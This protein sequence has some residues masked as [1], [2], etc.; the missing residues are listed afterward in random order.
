M[1]PERLHDS[2]FIS[3]IATQ[4]PPWWWLDSASLKPVSIFPHHL[5][6]TSQWPYILPNP[7]SSIHITG[8]SIV[9][10]PLADVTFDSC[11]LCICTPVAAYSLHLL[12]DIGPCCN[13][14]LLVQLSESLGFPLFRQ[15][16]PRISTIAKRHSLSVMHVSHMR[17]PDKLSASYISRFSLTLSPILEEETSNRLQ[18]VPPFNAG[19]QLNGMSQILRDLDHLTRYIMEVVDISPWS[20]VQPTSPRDPQSIP[21]IVISDENESI[22]DD[23]ATL[24]DV[25]DRT[26]LDIYFDHSCLETLD[27]RLL[28]HPTDSSADI[29][30][31]EAVYDDLD[32]II[33][34]I[35][36]GTS[37]SNPMTRRDQRRVHFQAQDLDECRTYQGDYVSATYIYREGDDSGEYTSGYN[38]PASHNLTGYR[39]LVE[40]AFSY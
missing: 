25:F 21:D 29:C 6:T 5:C 40:F 34:P 14:K 18:P 12:T 23:E 19:P 36:W 39:I 7:N 13:K 27:D 32:R 15:V 26:S 8:Q 11:F 28:L 3:F 35:E 2:E 20:D 24:F 22:W 10:V 31:A 33:T 16:P 4:R 1:D 37:T 30:W 38:L 9:D 17:M